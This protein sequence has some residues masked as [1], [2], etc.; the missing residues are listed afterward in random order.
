MTTI[1][2]ILGGAQILLGISY[3]VQDCFEQYLTAE[4]RTFLATLRLLGQYQPAIE[5]AGAA[6]GRP[7]YENEPF[8]RAFLA[9]SFFRI[10]STEDLRNR[11]IADPNLRLICGFTEVPSAA[12]FS[13][14]LAMLSKKA[15][16]TRMLNGLGVDFYKD[17]IVGH[18]SRDSTAIDARE[19][20]VNKKRDVAPRL[21]R[22]RGRPR[23]G[24][25]R[26]ERKRS[27]I[28][29]QL[30]MKP[31]KAVAELDRACSW[32]CKTNSQGNVTFWK[33]YKLHLDVTDQGIPVTAVVTGANVHDSQAAIPMEKWTERKLDFLYSVMDSAY[34]AGP[35]LGYIQGK[36]RVPLI[37]PNK[38]RGSE[39]RTFTPAQRERFQVRTTVE[40]ANS[41]LKDW[42]LPPQIF[43]RGILKVSFMLM[44]GA[45][46]LA[47]LK[48]LQAIAPP[49]SAAA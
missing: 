30:R 9:K 13:R 25:Q 8:L 17:R 48:V 21:K 5:R 35:I 11:L 41:H 49:L 47:A 32:G 42:L 27:R 31:G 37:D 45:L 24:E 1:T 46:L 23:K 29:Q 18:I 22:K 14:R 34:D 33:G 12:T 3:D 28:E 20:P 43:V 4:Q 38:R 19:A 36:G 6:T 2:K 10:P 16:P 39:R 44:C 15:V 40:R 26:P 7:A